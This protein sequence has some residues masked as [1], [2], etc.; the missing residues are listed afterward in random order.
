MTVKKIL[1]VGAGNM[2][3]GI[4]QLCAQQGFEVVLSDISL[5]FCTKAKARIEKGLQKRVEQGKMAEAD[6]T[7]IL[8][9]LSLAGDLTAAKECDFVIESVLNRSRSKERYSPSWTSSR[10]ARSFSQRTPLPF[11]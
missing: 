11:R 9:R 4:A 3:A 6:K 2:G 10:E 8:S 7:A 5:D 1:V